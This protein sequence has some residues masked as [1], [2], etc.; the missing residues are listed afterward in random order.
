MA[1]AQRECI[2]E[3]QAKAEF[4]SF[5][6]K[7]PPTTS[8]YVPSGRFPFGALLWNIVGS[9]LGAAAGAV[10][11]TAVMGLTLGAV[12]L[13]AMLLIGA[14]E[15]GII[16][17]GGII[18]GVIAA[19][20]ALGCIYFAIGW[21]ATECVAYFSRI[22]KSR[23]IKGLFLFSVISAV[24]ATVAFR[25]PVLSR[26]FSYV[27]IA[28]IDHVGKPIAWIFGGSVFAWVITVLGLGVAAFAAVAVAGGRQENL[29]FCEDCDRTMAIDK[30]PSVSLDGV[31][32]AVEAVNSQQWAGAAE[33]LRTCTQLN[34]A[35][36]KVYQ[37]PRCGSGYLELAV[38]IN[39]AIRG[40]KQTEGGN[41]T[42]QW[43]A[44]SWALTGGQ[45]EPFRRR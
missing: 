37:C 34:E 8:A 29:K 24:A 45:I 14:F 33:A 21:A 26:V 9:G 17:I 18:M 25:W 4:E 6:A 10:A 28:E 7:A 12:S 41:F 38:N 20:A 23:N 43:L 30:L 32:R 35:K 15:S 5:Q 40:Y 36:P 19:V 31:V 42:A 1:K 13:F 22:G 39:W 16:H 27:G 3:T 2:N 11:G 44:G